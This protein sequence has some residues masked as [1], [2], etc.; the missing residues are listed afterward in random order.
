LSSGSIFDVI[1]VVVVRVD[2]GIDWSYK[3]SM[4]TITT[5]HIIKVTI[6][7]Q[8]LKF[9]SSNINPVLLPNN[10]KGKDISY[11]GIKLEGKSACFVIF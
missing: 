3:Q 10:K 8:Q 1:I 9:Q 5:Q 4:R 2:I 11:F 6:T 7:N